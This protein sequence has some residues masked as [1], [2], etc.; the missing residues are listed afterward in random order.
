LG[1]I[2][3]VLTEEIQAETIALVVRRAGPVV[4]G[5]ELE[6]S[7]VP[8]NGTKFRI[9]LKRPR[10]RPHPGKGSGAVP[11]M[12]KGDSASKSPSTGSSGRLETSNTSN[13]GS[14][15]EGIP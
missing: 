6:N 11:Y 10:I 12:S 7:F 8:E 14:T 13:R 2:Q 4:V 1:E 3:E 9:V 5:E 15:N